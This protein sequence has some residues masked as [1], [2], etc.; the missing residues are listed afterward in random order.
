MRASE[1]LHVPADPI[2]ARR[3]ASQ[4]A[5]LSYVPEPHPI[6]LAGR[7][8]TTNRRSKETP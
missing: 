2:A 8:P 1:S 7:G 4:W 6:H 5:P 3:A